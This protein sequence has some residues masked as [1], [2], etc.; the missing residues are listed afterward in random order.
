MSKGLMS[1]ACL[2][3]LCIECGQ[4]KGCFVGSDWDWTR[5]FEIKSNSKKGT[6]AA[7][8]NKAEK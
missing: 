2:I 4:V 5:A 6:V 1:R 3:K 8:R 7:K